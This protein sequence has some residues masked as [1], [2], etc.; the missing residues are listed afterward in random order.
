MVVKCE[1]DS[2]FPEFP[3]RAKCPRCG[4]RWWF[5]GRGDNTITCDCD[6][7]FTVLIPKDCIPPTFEEL[8]NDEVG[9]RNT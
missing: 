4:V 5:S 3:W 1:Y 2:S 6:K 7:K 8:I 9:R